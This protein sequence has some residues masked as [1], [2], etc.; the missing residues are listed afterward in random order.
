MANTYDTPVLR[1]LT[2]PQ[3]KIKSYVLFQRIT[4]DGA[5][6]L[7]YLPGEAAAAGVYPTALARVMIEQFR[8]KTIHLK[9]IAF[10]CPA[11]TA[12]TVFVAQMPIAVGSIGNELMTVGSQL[13]QPGYGAYLELDLRTDFR[14]WMG[15]LIYISNSVEAQANQFRVY[16][17]VEE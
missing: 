5:T 12:M 16:F 8:G 14:S 6:T 17:E 3:A 7:G 9:G 1:E 4:G 2:N 13:V 10:D 15:G 11:N